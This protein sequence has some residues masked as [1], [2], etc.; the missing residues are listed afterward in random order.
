L[1]H[2][3]Q[4]LFGVAASTNNSLITQFFNRSATSGASTNYG[5][6]GITGQS[7]ALF[8][9]G[10]NTITTAHNTLDDGSGNMTLSTSNGGG[11]ATTP[12]WITNASVAAGGAVYMEIGQAQSSD[13]CGVFGFL[14]SATLGASTA[15][16]TA[17]G[18]LNSL[19]VAGNG[20]IFTANSTLDN[21]SGA[22]T[23][24]GSVTLSN[25]QLVNSSG[26]AI[27]LPSSAGTLALAGGTLG[28]LYATISGGNTLVTFPMA[29]VH[30]GNGL[31]YNGSGQV[32]ANPGTYL[33]TICITGSVSNGTTVQCTSTVNSSFA[34]YTPQTWTFI[35]SSSSTQNITTTIQ[36][37]MVVNTAC[38]CTWGPNTTA[39]ASSVAGTIQIQ[40]LY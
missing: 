17:Y 33:C 10:T 35:N 27:T 28:Y 6:L 39:F 18:S 31:T 22:A 8:F 30:S 19:Q 40:Q 9:N 24:A 25:N 37:M 32:M 12:L 16:M 36:Q 20:R 11:T 29:N 7:N 3:T 34:T 14:K 1:L 5:S 15:T 23:F 26:N 21:G 2:N 38:L 13:N 4:M